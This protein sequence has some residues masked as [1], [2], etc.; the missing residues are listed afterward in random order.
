MI[1]IPWSSLLPFENVL[2]LIALVFL[3]EHSVNFED[4]AI[5]KNLRRVRHKHTRRSSAAFM[6]IV[7][8]HIHTSIYRYFVSSTLN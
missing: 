6:F 1:D 5:F 2:W 3:G 8:D 7:F 4:P